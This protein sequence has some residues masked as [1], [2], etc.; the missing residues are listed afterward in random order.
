VPERPLWRFTPD[1]QRL[2]WITV[3]ATFAG[4]LG[5][6]ILGAVIVGAAFAFAQ[7]SEPGA[8]LELAL[9]AFLASVIA[10]GSIYRLRERK[11]RMRKLGNLVLLVW[12]GPLAVLCILALIGLAA[13]IT[14]SGAG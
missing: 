11:S 2:L 14:G 3:V 1:E 8:W 12:F 10:G 9:G 5:S 4:G 6:I 13:R 7:A